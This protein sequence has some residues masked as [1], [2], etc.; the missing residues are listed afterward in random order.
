MAETLMCRA[1]T[2]PLLIG[3][4]LGA[5]G[6]VDRLH[7]LIL[8]P[9]DGVRSIVWTEQER[10]KNIAVRTLRRTHEA[11]FH[12][13]RLVT[14]EEPHVHE[15]SDLTVFVLSGRV[16]IHLADRVTTV[17]PGDVIWIPRHIVHWA[18][19]LHPK[20]SEAYAISSPPLDHD[21]HKIVE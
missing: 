5:V 2:A 4:S 9:E 7:S 1:R 3:L 19:N 14:T 21:N 20:A 11:S 12:L 18:E 8:T 15:R 10:A 6:C 13:V 17:G 16:R